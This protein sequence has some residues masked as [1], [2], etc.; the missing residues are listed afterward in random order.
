MSILINRIKKDPDEPRKK[1]TGRPV[2]TKNI[3]IKITLVAIALFFLFMLTSSLTIGSGPLKY[4]VSTKEL[5]TCSLT[6]S[7]WTYSKSQDLM[8]V[9][10]TVE[11]TYLEPELTYRSTTMLFVQNEAKVDVIGIGPDICVLQ[12]HA[13][14]FSEVKLEI[15]DGGEENATFY[16]NKDKI[17]R[18]D[19]IE[20]KTL[21]EYRILDR[22]A[23]IDLNNQRIQD[24]YTDN[25]NNRQHIVDLQESIENLTARKRYMTTKQIQDADSEIRSMQLD[26]ENTETKI[27]T[28]I[29]SVAEL[30]ERNRLLEQEIKDIE[31]TITKGE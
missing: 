20:N 22:N 5:K 27:Q 30:M 3:Q 24:L 14:D 26:I 8:E 1:R 9:I 21:S 13:N 7:S 10:I 29:D 2:E 19:K 15:S 16:N 28:N 17:T 18:T 23:K 11:N 12:I 25:E 4:D 31:S 6:V